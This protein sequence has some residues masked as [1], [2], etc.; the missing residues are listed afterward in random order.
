MIASVI[1]GT[2]YAQPQTGDAQGQPSPG[3]TAATPSPQWTKIKEVLPW[4]AWY[5]DVGRIQRS[6]NTVTVWTLVKQNFPKGDFTAEVRQVEFDCQTPGRRGL[7]LELYV[8]RDEEV[9]RDGGS[10][11]SDDT[12]G[13]WQEIADPENNVEGWAWQFACRGVH[14]VASHKT[15]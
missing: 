10:I 5:I 14:P 13:Q 4:F 11:S 3:W 1:F 15:S 7:Y 2:A 9:S 8:T 12:A 6:E